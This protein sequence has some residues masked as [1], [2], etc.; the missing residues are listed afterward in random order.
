M[1][2]ASATSAAGRERVRLAD[3]IEARA[4]AD[5]YGAAPAALKSRLG[6][7]T[8][9]R[10][11]ATVLVAPGLP[12]P[13]FNRVIGVGTEHAVTPREIESLLELYRSAAVP[14][15]WLHWSPCAEPG[16]GL[17]LLA[18]MGFAVSARRNWAQMQRSTADPPRVR[19]E[20]GI[21]AATAI[22]VGAAA[23]CIARGFGMPDFVGDWIAA[24]HGRRSWRVYAVA[25]GDTVVGG[26]CL[27][28]DGDAAWLGM[29]AV[30][31][32]HRR[33]GG[34]GALMA[35]RIADAG[36]AGCELVATETG[37]PVGD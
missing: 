19:S 37:E 16:D 25:D 14:R 18:P 10:A 12:T 36:A 20:L 28:V 4:Y 2:A 11:G 24:Q 30:L 27:F 5:L 33:R 34:Q 9:Y 29:A 8:E 35:R 21:E 7:R 15:W 13:M 31:P 23:A 26:A 3:R 17:A 32:S 6:L 22:T 1:T